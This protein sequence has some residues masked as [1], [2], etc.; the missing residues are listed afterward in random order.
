MALELISETSRSYIKHNTS[1]GP[2]AQIKKESLGLLT[3]LE[4]VWVFLLKREKE[5]KTQTN[6]TSAHFKYEWANITNDRYEITLYFRTTKTH[7][8]LLALI[9]VE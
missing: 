3:K 8:F 2:L 9:F 5:K 6:V 4:L 1:L 7:I